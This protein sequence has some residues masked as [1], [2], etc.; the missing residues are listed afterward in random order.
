MT[1]LPGP[2]IEKPNLA[3]SSS[4]RPNYLNGKKDQ[5]KDKFS[6]KIGQNINF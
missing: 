3:I 2:K 1:G 4:K 6:K 5:L